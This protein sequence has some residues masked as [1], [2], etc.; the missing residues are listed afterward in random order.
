MLKCLHLTNFRNYEKGDFKFD[1][2]TIFIG[3]NGTGKT[4]IIEAIYLLSTGRSWRTSKDSEVVKWGEDFAKISA[5]IAAE[6]AH[7]LDLVIQK[8]GYEAPLI[9]TIKI[10]DVKRKLVDLL[11]TLPAVLF[12]PEALEMASGAPALRRRFLDILLCQTDKK[13]TL[14]LIEL[15]KVLKSR[16]KLLFY[17]KLGKSKP[18]ELDFWDE[19]LVEL[20]TFII[21]K[22][23]EA[24]GVLNKKVSD[25]YSEISGQK[26]ELLIKYHP[27]VLPDQFAETLV[28]VR[29]REIENTISMHGPHRDDF[30]FSLDG[31][32]LTTFGSRGEFRTTILA[33]KMGELE[34]LK[35]NLEAEPVL[36]L[37]DI[38]S[39][40]DAV[41]R[42]HLVKI[43]ES[44]Q[45]IISTTDL[46]H[47]EDNLKKKAKIV[48]VPAGTKHNG[49]NK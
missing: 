6:E 20:G 35:K 32:D 3:P 24:I 21:Q 46:D 31:R 4:N 45:T 34:Y 8:Q 40:L 28:A 37:D 10:N 27:S 42:L 47:I 17:I 19:K 39:E 15:G 5:E 33:L 38:F 41:R 11:G 7:Q 36:L 48:E 25:I 44:Q 22:R 30:L 9:K 12:S 18:D 26:E 49:K 14:N 2:T 23:K 16:N 1:K 29:E 43:V 13:Y